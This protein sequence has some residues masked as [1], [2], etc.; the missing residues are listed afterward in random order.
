MNKQVSKLE[1][2]EKEKATL[3]QKLDG[4]KFLIGEYRLTNSFGGAVKITFAHNIYA[5]VN[6]EV[7]ELENYLQALE[8]NTCHETLTLDFK[9]ATQK[10]YWLQNDKIREDMYAFAD[11]K[12]RDYNMVYIIDG[13]EFIDSIE[14]Y[15]AIDEGFEKLIVLLKKVEEV[16]KNITK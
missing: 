4:L 15:K 6:D 5:Y 10:S 12:I 16:Q 8:E 7:E 13:K 2:K 1:K 11:K 3:Q 9:E 14:L